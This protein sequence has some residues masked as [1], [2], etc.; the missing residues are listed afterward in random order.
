MSAEEMER[1][2]ANFRQWLSR[3]LLMTAYLLDRSGRFEYRAGCYKFERGWQQPKSEKDLAG[4]PRPSGPPT[5]TM[6][7]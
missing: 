6:V 4:P 3:K 5:H 2:M 7:A 1:K